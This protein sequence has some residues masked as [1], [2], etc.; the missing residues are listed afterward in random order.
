MKK[1]DLKKQF[2]H[3]YTPTP[4]QVV[5]VEVPRFIKKR[6]KNPLDYPVM[7]LEGLWWTKNSHKEFAVSRAEDWS[8]TL[9]I[10][11]PAPVTRPLF[12]QAR[13]QLRE[14]KKSAKLAQARF[15]AMHEGRSMQVMHIGPYSAEPATIEK[16]V[17]FAAEN[18]YRVHGRHHEIYFGDPRRT[19]PEKLKTILRHPIK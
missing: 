7:P 15:D 13:Q 5:I 17:A 8:F 9:L 1:L 6:K 4:K 3:L 10:M 16:M 19:R 11:Q 18:G 12:E 14:K 2:K